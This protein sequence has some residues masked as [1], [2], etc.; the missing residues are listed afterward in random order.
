MHIS[1]MGQPGRA[2]SVRTSAAPSTAFRQ[3]SLAPLSAIGLSVTCTYVPIG[4]YV[5]APPAAFI[6]PPLL[7]MFALA[8]QSARGLRIYAVW[9]GSGLWSA[10]VAIVLVSLNFEV[11]GLLAFVTPFALAALKLIAA[12]LV[13]IELAEIETQRPIRGWRGLFEVRNGPVER[14]VKASRGSA[15]ASGRGGADSGGGDNSRP[16]GRGDY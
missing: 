2:R 3:H 14:T 7:G 16:G 5:A 8:S 10:A 15:K 1:E 12:Q 4:I 11:L 9:N 13:P 6:A